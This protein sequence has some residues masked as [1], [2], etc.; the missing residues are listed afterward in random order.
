MVKLWGDGPQ[1]H[2]GALEWHPL[3]PGGGQRRGKPSCE[4]SSV[5][6]RELKS[7]SRGASGQ[8]RKSPYGRPSP[9]QANEEQG[10][11]AGDFCDLSKLTWRLGKQKLASTWK[12]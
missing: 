5:R 6:G 3:C 9:A 11:H 10:K 7:V 2:N 8:G 12:L 1:H 4:R